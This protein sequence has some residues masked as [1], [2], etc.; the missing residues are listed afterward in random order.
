MAHKLAM[1]AC[2]KLAQA[3]VFLALFLL[4]SC[5]TTTHSSRSQSRLNWQTIALN[6][7]TQSWTPSLETQSVHELFK[8]LDAD[9]NGLLDEDG[10]HEEYLDWNGFQRRWLKNPARAWKTSALEF[11]LE[12]A[13]LDKFKEHARASKW[14][15]K[16]LP[17]LAT[18]NTDVYRPLSFA[19]PTLKHK[20][21]LRAFDV[22]IFGPHARSSSYQSMFYLEIVIVVLL[23]LVLLILVAWAWTKTATS[24]DNVEVYLWSSDIVMSWLDRQQFSADVKKKLEKVDGRMLLEMTHNDIATLHL[25]QED[26]EKFTQ[27]VGDLQYLCHSPQD[28]GVEHQGHP[29][30]ARLSS[31]FH[32]QSS[33][34][35]ILEQVIAVD[36]HGAPR[37]VHRGVIEQQERVGQGQFGVVWRAR[38]T[39]I[40]DDTGETDSQIVAV[41]VLKSA[42][43]LPGDPDDFQHQSSKENDAKTPTT[44]GFE[45][46]VDVLRSLSHPNI[47]SFIAAVPHP[48]PIVMTAFCNG[49]TLYSFLHSE[50]KLYSLKWAQDRA[51]EIAKGMEYLANQNIIHRDLKSK[52]IMLHVLGVAEDI[53]VNWDTIECEDVM[54]IAKICD[55]GLARGTD[56]LSQMTLNVGTPAWMAPEIIE[57]SSNSSKCDIYS[58]GIVLWEL[59]TKQTPFLNMEVFS[60]FFNVVR[61]KK[62]PPIP[63]NCHPDF[64]QL[65]EKCWNQKPSERPS[66]TEIWIELD[67]ISVC[68]TQDCYTLAETQADWRNEIKQAFNI[69]DQD[70]G[71]QSAD[72]SD[73]ESEG[74]APTFLPGS[75]LLRRSLSAPPQA[76][77]EPAVSVHATQVQQRPH[78]KDPNATLD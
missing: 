20:L 15:G 1:M 34:D 22:V 56:H 5:P 29:K 48:H 33:D 58:F 77:D 42:A 57:G 68:E 4:S 72:S 10:E 78:I 18:G 23:A 71:A 55:F 13:G 7:E 25:Q 16:N 69:M 41:K 36:T 2:A 67:K 46:E 11:W 53:R 49:G 9:G 14:C 28:S 37:L 12:S 45:R 50:S 61:H 31:S 74:P 40:Y 65:I 64:A 6:A 26:H 32:D 52:N 3:I 76:I 43:L 66:F 47:I 63:A 44:P 24:F 75:P 59:V 35:V 51:I 60:I 19:S 30:L 62:R 54:I 39:A 73:T 21:Q 17:E 38:W 8:Q 70:A 27:A